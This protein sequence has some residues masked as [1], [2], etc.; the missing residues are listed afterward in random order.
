MQTGTQ[1]ESKNTELTGHS[2]PMSGDKSATVEASVNDKPLPSSSNALN[3]HRSWSA[4]PNNDSQAIVDSIDPAAQRRRTV[5]DWSHDI[6]YDV[7][8]HSHEVSP[9][10]SRVIVQRSLVCA[11]EVRVRD[12]DAEIPGEGEDEGGDSCTTTSVASFSYL[13][14]S[15]EVCAT[16]KSMP[17]DNDGDNSL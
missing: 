16:P 8:D 5:Y 4:H 3:Y 9:N 17:L 14:S 6:D 11:V 7:I 13:T 2:A 12:A 1:A 15:T 10:A